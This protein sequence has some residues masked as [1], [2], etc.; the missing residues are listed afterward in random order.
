MPIRWAALCTC[1]ITFVRRSALLSV[2][3]YAG[4]KMI[5]MLD[6]HLIL[7]EGVMGSGKST[8]T[9][10]IVHTLRQYGYQA[11]GVNEADPH[12]TYVFRTLPHWQKIWLDVTPE[13]FID[14][15]YQ[16]WAAFVQT[17][18]KKPT[19]V[20]FDGQFFHGDLT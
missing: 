15:S 4:T 20:V 7:V 10:F 11:K 18:R 19:I 14:L 13:T 9:R 5:R 3:L 8:L 1:E 2:Y 17:I 12:P 6:T 16:R